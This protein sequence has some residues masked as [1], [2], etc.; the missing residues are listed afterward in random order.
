MP[1][2]PG[3][4]T[5]SPTDAPTGGPTAGPTSGSTH[6]PNH[7]VRWHYD[8]AKTEVG[9]DLTVTVNM[10]VTVMMAKIVILDN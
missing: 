1:P 6:D 8:D 3:P 5:T 9:C 7:Q 4:T 10:T 2:H